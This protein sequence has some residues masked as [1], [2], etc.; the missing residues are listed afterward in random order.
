[1]GSRLA[2]LAVVFSALC[3]LGSC[4]PKEDHRVAIA[5]HGGA[6]TIDR[7][8]LTPEKE[9]EIRATLERAVRTGHDIL[10]QG[11]SSVAAVE[12][13][14]VVLEDS[15][16]F[17]AG[18]GAVFNAEGV[19]E[20]DASIMDGA[21][22]NAGA[23]A[24]VRHIRNP[25][26]LAL[27][28]MNKS[29]HV[30]LI[31]DGAEEFARQQGFELVDAKYFY[32]D[33]R[34]QQLQKAKAATTGANDTPQHWYST[35]GAVARDKNGNLAA[36]TS[37]GGLTNK[38]WGRVGDSPIIGAGTYASNDSCAVSGTGTG[39]YFIRHVVAYS[40]CSRVRH[41]ASIAE[42]AN[43]VI[44]GVLVKDGGDGGV[45]A[46]D[47][48]GNFALVRNT[49]GMYRASIDKTGKLSVQIWDE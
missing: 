41:G 39:E 17:N 33:F 2:R 27:A 28:V 7:A 6:G 3:I 36:G 9:A 46:M 11:G 48:D 31:G 35:V 26:K 16:L 40:I 38:Q 22:L 23:V 30:M 4:A 43:A 14:I 20:L 32:T 47:K 37:T 12:A 13:A 15:P 5:I 34:W 24:A 42:A 8:E 29:R 44:N 49:T 45:I 10:T 18:K 1:M 25:I 19:N 21:T